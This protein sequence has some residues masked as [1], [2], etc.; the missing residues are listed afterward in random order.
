M[1]ACKIGLHIWTEKCAQASRAGRC[2]SH[3]CDTHPGAAGLPCH[4]PWRRTSAAPLPLAPHECRA[5]PN[6][7][8]PLD[9]GAWVITVAFIAPPG[10]AATCAAPRSLA[11][12]IC[13]ATPL[14]TAGLLCHGPWRRTPRAGIPSDHSSVRCAARRCCRLCHAMQPGA[15]H[16][17]CPGPW[18][19]RPGAP[20][21]R[22]CLGLGVIMS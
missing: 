20:H 15:A 22:H 21:D 12:H 6:S 17:P 14:D 11:L 3:F 19:R 4:S 13:R 5:T 16:L 8:A 18:H 7:A 1:C 10:T 2:N 9:L